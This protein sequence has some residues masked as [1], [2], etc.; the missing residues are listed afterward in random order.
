MKD[1]LLKEEEEEEAVDVVRLSQS[2]ALD[3]LINL[4]PF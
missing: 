4:N 2:F 1:N 3:C